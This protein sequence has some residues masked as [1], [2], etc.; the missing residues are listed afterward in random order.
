MHDK[1]PHDK[2]WKTKRE[3]ETDA[4]EPV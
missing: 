3:E 1:L 2:S 4:S